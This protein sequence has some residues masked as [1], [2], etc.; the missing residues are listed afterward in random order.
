MD[1]VS[2]FFLTLL[3]Q[4]LNKANKNFPVAG[5]GVEPGKQRIENKD[6]TTKPYLQVSI[7]R[8]CSIFIGKICHRTPLFYGIC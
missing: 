1:D 2:D 7:I 4:N 5:V 8:S 6:V 3:Q